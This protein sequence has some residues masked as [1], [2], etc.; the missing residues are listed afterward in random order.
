MPCEPPGAAA[1][2]SDVN[3]RAWDRLSAGGS[4]SSRPFGADALESVAAWLCPTGWLPWDEAR[5][6]LVLGGGGGQQGPAFALLGH[7]VVVA[8]LSA[9]QLARDEE[10][11]GAL[12]V[13]LECVQADMLDLSALRGR[14]FDLVHQPVSACYVPDVERLYAE[15]AR[16]LRSGG[17]Y[18][19][20]HWN[21]VH[22][23]LRGYGEWV[24]DAYAI[25]R[26]QGTGLPIPWTL[27]SDDAPEPV[28]CWHFAHRL[29]DLIGG[30]C[31]AGFEVQRFS[32][33]THGDSGAPP[34]SH[35]HLATFAPPFMRIAARLR[36]SR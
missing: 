21:P 3:G 30:L 32:E 28:E 25:A 27:A 7:D 8:D 31:R 16:V 35:A 2:Y 19:V 20:E 29:H 15:V 6:V 36:D 17:W 4:D 34:G 13:T 22:A 14:R 23:Q 9:E 10:A 5:R 1:V 24:D 26:P 18:D 33:R 12:G 11:A